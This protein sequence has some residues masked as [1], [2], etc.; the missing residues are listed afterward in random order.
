MMPDAAVVLGRPLSI[1]GYWFR[2][3]SLAELLTL[4]TG[5]L[6][7]H[8]LGIWPHLVAGMEPSQIRDELTRHEVTAYC[9]NVPGE[10]RLNS[11]GH[12]EEAAQALAET[13]ELAS[14][15]GVTL[16]QIYAGTSPALD[17]H[18]NVEAYAC[19]L[20]P[21]VRR[22]AKRGI[23]LAV[24]NN[25]DQRG[26]DP[27][28][29]NPSRR[30]ER[31]LALAEL[32]DEP[33]FGLVY[34]P[35]NFYTVGISPFPEPYELLAPWIVSVEFKDVVPFDEQVHGPRGGQ[36]LLTDTITGSHLP[37]PVGQG[38]VQPEPIL[39]RLAADAYDG[40]VAFDPFA[41]ADTLLDQCRQSVAALTAARGVGAARRLAEV[42]S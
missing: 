20:R 14:Q 15:L 8:S 16:V 17:A 6:G 37:V 7:I 26:E 12:E 41:D 4:M 33:N 19:A 31:L 27:N 39:A 13:L 40:V 24:E 35:C 9:L 2:D 29:V 25:L 28:G 5:D 23:T 21:W 34:D 18:E 36:R 10:H 32:I 30:P 38:A 1:S 11:P 42:Q 3:H 22:A